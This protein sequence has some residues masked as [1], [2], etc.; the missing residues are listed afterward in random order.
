MDVDA[1]IYLTEGDDLKIVIPAGVVLSLFSPPA[2]PPLQLQPK[3]LAPLPPVVVPPPP[4]RREPIAAYMEIERVKVAP[5]ALAHVRIFGGA[6]APINGYWAHVRYNK[7][8]AVHHV[9]LGDFFVKHAEA[10]GERHDD[11]IFHTKERRTI[12]TLGI[13]YRLF[14]LTSKSAEKSIMVP[15]D[16]TLCTIIFELL[17]G[18]KGSRISRSGT[19]RQEAIADRPS[20]Y[21]ADGFPN[22]IHPKVESGGI[23]LEEEQT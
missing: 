22:G 12:D 21:T 5:G 23:E 18:S 3:P 19:D 17:E 13:Y 2:P 4:P 1:R 14:S 6:A 16:T 15:P 20:I 8:V 10:D 11:L 7:S 9:E